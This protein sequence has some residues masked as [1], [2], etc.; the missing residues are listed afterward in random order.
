MKALGR[1]ALF[2]LAVVFVMS[3]C[4]S[5]TEIATEST[6][7]SAAPVPGEKIPGEGGLGAGAGPG[8]ANASVHW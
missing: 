5:T 1:R 8:T 7:T 4:A 2:L 3:S 6:T